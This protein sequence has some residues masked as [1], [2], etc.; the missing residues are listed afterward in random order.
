M[1]ERME[2]PR[3]PLP[4]VQRPKMSTLGRER[5]RERRNKKNSAR[6]FGFFFC[7]SGKPDTSENSIWGGEGD[8][9]SK[10]KEP[11]HFLSLPS[12]PP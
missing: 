12:T 8:Q 2:L 1:K 3:N 10:G 4:P 6:D 5:E 7:Q 11:F 9:G